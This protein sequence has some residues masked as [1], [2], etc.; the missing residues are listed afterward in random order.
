MTESIIAPQCVMVFY[1]EIQSNSLH[2]TAAVFFGA[3]KAYYHLFNIV[4]SL[5]LFQSHSSNEPQQNCVFVCD[6]FSRFWAFSTT[7][8]SAVKY[9][10]YMYVVCTTWR[11]P[12]RE[13]LTS[14]W[15]IFSRD[16]KIS[17]V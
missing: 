3:V 7:V 17:Y 8:C 12:N 14:D 4:N 2:T 6:C 11:E 5:I 13:I 16:W 10:V 1:Y 9:I 15:F